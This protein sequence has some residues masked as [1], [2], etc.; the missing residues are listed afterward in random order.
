M[1][2]T[3]I[4]T[5]H[6]SINPQDRVIFGK[7]A[8]EAV[9]AEMARQGVSRAFVTSTASLARLSDGPLQAVL[10]GLGATCVGVHDHIRAHSPEE[11][12]VEA[13]KAA[14]AAGA[15]VLVAVGGGSVIDA[16]KA[17]QMC[18]WF[19]V[20]SVDAMREAGAKMAAAREA[21][22]GGAMRIIAVPTTLSAA[23][24]TSTAG[25][26]DTARGVKGGYTHPRMVPRAVVLDPAA[27]RATPPALLVSTG[28]RAMDH[29]AEGW[30]SPTANPMTDMFA[31]AAVK[32]LASSLPAILAAPDDLGP[33]QAAQF[34]M[35]Q[36]I[37]ALTGGAGSGA[38]HAAGYALGAAFGVPHGE[39]SCIMLPAVLR[40]NSEVNADRQQALAEAL[41]DPARPAWELMG[42][43]VR[44]LG[45]PSTLRDKGITREDLPRLAELAFDYAPMRRNPRPVGSPRD[46]EEFLDH[47]F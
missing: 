10:A 23:E 22:P 24:F 19:D 31:L 43:L 30:C 29:A 4:A 11:D 42:E 38:S 26:T 15:D 16:T 20:D 33:R 32:A 35:W 9:P 47:A 28:M 5:G 18:L 25:I 1:T 44:G 46:I 8:A 3:E 34:G 7:P 36:A 12:V 27:T 13:A 6:L 21:E 39:T 45:V 14:R 37:S 17:V 41:G 40:W 2:A